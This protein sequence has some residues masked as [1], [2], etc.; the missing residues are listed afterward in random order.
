M[1]EFGITPYVDYD[2]VE[3]FDDVVPPRVTLRETAAWDGDL[4]SGLHYD[5]VGKRWVS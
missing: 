5:E 2:E 4:E 1:E 3:D